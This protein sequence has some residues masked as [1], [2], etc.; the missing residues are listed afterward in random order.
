M[1][2]TNLY[3]DI[4]P[5]FLFS[6]ITSC[7]GHFWSFSF[8][9]FHVSYPLLMRERKQLPNTMMEQNSKKARSFQTKLKNSKRKNERGEKGMQ[10]IQ[11]SHKSQQQEL[12]S[13]SFE[14]HALFFEKGKRFCPQLSPLKSLFTV[15]AF[16]VSDAL[17][18]FYHSPL[19]PNRKHLISSL[20]VDE[21]NLWGKEEQL[22]NCD[23]C[24]SL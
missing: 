14:T 13:I 9:C 16:T 12:S 23:S 6:F 1:N 17:S 18:L 5:S 15:D 2:S 10:E 7:W 4:S 8:I 19:P 24:G 20:L 3:F 21:L 22:R 11:F